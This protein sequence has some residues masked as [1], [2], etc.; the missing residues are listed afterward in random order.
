MLDKLA[1]LQR[2]RQV[3]RSGET[4]NALFFTTLV[5]SAPKLMINVETDDYAVVEDRAAGCAIGELGFTRHLHTVRSYEKL[6][7]EGM[8]LRGAEVVTLLERTLPS[9]VGGAPTDYQLVEELDGALPRPLDRR[10]PPRGRDR[11]ARGGRGRPLRACARRPRRPGR[12]EDLAGRP[13]PYAWCGGSPTPDP[14]CE[15]PARARAPLAFRP[16]HQQAHEFLVA[17]LPLV[18]VGESPAPPQPGFI[19]QATGSAPALYVGSASHRA[20]QRGTLHKQLRR[21]DRAGRD[22]DRMSGSS[23]VL[24]SFS[25]E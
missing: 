17:L 9:L 24:G 25:A 10:Q 8:T 15:D 23:I 16:L 6:T 5:G 11:R 13:G 12:V 18:L 19:S 1:V 20:R 2:P 22:T 3:P 14:A 4:V 21:R 7:S